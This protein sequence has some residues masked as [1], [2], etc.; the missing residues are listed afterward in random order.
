MMR[1][2][3]PAVEL[4]GRYVDEMYSDPENTE[5]GKLFFKHA[6]L[7]LNVMNLLDEDYEEYPG[8]EAPGFFIIGGMVLKF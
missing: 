1:E 3:K 2:D 5:E 7:Y 6:E 4:V 8:S